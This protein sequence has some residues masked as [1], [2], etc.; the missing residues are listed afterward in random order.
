MERM[1]E[2][3]RSGA[4]RPGQVVPSYRALAREFE[5]GE[6]TVRWALAALKAEASVGVNAR[7]RL[8]VLPQ[9]NA[10]TVTQR[11]VLEILSAFMD[12]WHHAPGFSELQ[13]GIEISLGHW[14]CTLTISGNP[15]YRH[16]VPQDALDMNLTGILLHGH[17][18]KSVLRAYERLPVPV[19]LVDRPRD[20]WQMH[21]CSVD[22]ARAAYDATKRLIDLGHRRI[23]YAIPY[24][25]HV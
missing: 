13:R 20:K 18:Q 8:I 11:V 9:Q 6:T 17:F 7:R 3:I 16:G 15:R 1:R 24:S 10:V 12:D 23:A 5:V 21:A 19:V 2:R 14:P 22:N 4:W 25:L